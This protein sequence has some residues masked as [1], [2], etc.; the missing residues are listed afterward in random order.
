MIVGV[1]GQTGSGKSTVTTL[2]GFD[3]ID[4]DK[5]AHEVLFDRE[6]KALLCERFGEDILGGDGEIFRPALAKKAFSDTNSLSLLGA[7]TYPVITKRILDKISAFEKNGAKII[8]LDAPTLYESGSDKMCQKVLFVTADREVRK[9]RI[10]ARDGLSDEAAE[11]RLSA[12]KDDGFYS[13]ADF[14]IVNNGEETALKEDV[15][16]LKETLIKLTEE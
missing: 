5:V 10:M 2:L 4:A 16:R 13:R 8:M 11:L 1:T 12:Q 6:V 3:S 7:V 9:K 15:R 14:K